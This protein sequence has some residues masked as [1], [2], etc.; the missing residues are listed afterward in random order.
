M[1]WSLWKRAAPNVI[2]STTRITQAGLSC[3]DA[4]LR[5]CIISL[6]K[7]ARRSGNMKQT[8]ITFGAALALLLG[9]CYKDKGHYDINMPTVPLVANLDDQYEATVGD[10]LVIEPIVEGAAGDDIELEWRI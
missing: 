9:G 4:M 1:C 8:I 7:T 6:T 3:C 2:I 5:A 10:S